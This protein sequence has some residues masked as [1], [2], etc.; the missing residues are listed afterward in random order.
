M[1]ANF[2]RRKNYLMFL[3][4]ANYIYDPKYAN[5]IEQKTNVADKIFDVEDIYRQ[6][7]SF[8]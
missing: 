3:K 4:R 1:T 7:A 2:K 8:I 5:E 6:I